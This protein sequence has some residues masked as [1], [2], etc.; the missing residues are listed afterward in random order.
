MTNLITN[1]HK[2]LEHAKKPT[3]FQKRVSARMLRRA[4]S[5]EIADDSA[6][7]AT[8]STK[9]A[10]RKRSG[11]CP[12]CLAR[13][14]KNARGTRYVRSCSQCGAQFVPDLRCPRCETCRV[15]RGRDECRCKGCGN[16]VS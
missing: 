3:R 13:L 4:A 5:A 11:N 9:H 14:T 12:V 6:S 8:R 2:K 7:P 15:W 16:S 1:K 10:D